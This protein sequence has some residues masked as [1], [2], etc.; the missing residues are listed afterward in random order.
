MIRSIKAR[1]NKTIWKRLLIAAVVLFFVIDGLLVA[2]WWTNRI[3][4]ADRQT[5]KSELATMK[6]RAE[7]MRGARTSFTSAVPVADAVV[8][9]NAEMLQLA[10][11][12]RSALADLQQTQTYRHGKD[13]TREYVQQKQVVEGYGDSMYQFAQSY[14][15]FIDV[16][17][18]CEA[19]LSASVLDAVVAVDELNVALTPCEAALKDTPKVPYEP[20]NFKIYQPYK[21]RVESAIA[22]L[23]PL[24][25]AVLVNGDIAAAQRLNAELANLKAQSDAAAAN[26]ATVTMPQDPTDALQRLLDQLK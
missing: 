10:S 22:T 5:A 1:K 15:Q 9:A 26:P 20:I 18:V 14:K 4:D 13:F 12:Y 23:R 24:Y 17:A 11:E 21:I 2:Y 3:P 8:K 6:D 19:S 16:S 7:R 25:Q